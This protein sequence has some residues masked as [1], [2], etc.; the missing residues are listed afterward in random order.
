MRKKQA[1]GKENRLRKIREI[2]RVTQEQLGAASGI[3]Q[4]TISAIER[5]GRR[6]LVDTAIRLARAL[7]K[8]TGRRYAVEEI[9]VVPEATKKGPPA[10]GRTRG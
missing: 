2:H 7:S 9:F 6:P 1:G 10:S 3:R 8:L 4:T 5:A